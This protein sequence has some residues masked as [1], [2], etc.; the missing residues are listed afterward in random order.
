MDSLPNRLRKLP[1]VMRIAGAYANDCREAAGEIERLTAHV[2]VLETENADLLALDGHKEWQR[3]DKVVGEKEAEIERLRRLL[4]ECMDE[5]ER[6]S[7]PEDDVDGLV[8]R[9]STEIGLPF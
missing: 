3:L 1:D 5:L 7:M 4:L 6:I 8:S 2:N 9:V